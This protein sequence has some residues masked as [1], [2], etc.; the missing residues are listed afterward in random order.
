MNVERGELPAGPE[1]NALL[2]GMTWP[3]SMGCT[4]PSIYGKVS[5]NV[6]LEINPKRHFMQFY[7]V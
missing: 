5:T 7:W 2:S 6:S 1:T 4:F 3:G